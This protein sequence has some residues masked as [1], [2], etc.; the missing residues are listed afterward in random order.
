MSTLLLGLHRP[1]STLLHRLPA[2]AKL[3]LLAAASIVIAVVRGPASAWV[4]VAVAVALLAWAGA[5][6]RTTLRSLRGPRAQLLDV[7]MSR[8]ASWAASVPV[9]EAGGHRARPPRARQPTGVAAGPG[10]HTA[11]ILEEWLR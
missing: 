1:G 11:E 8:V 5:D 9:S 6:P 10:T 7:A 4:A 2:G 3:L